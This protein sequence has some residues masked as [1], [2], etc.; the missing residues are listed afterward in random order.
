MT[1][2]VIIFSAYVVSTFVFYFIANIVCK[3][4]DWDREMLLPASLAW[5]CTLIGIVFFMIF[6]ALECASDSVYRKIKDLIR[7]RKKKKRERKENK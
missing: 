3:L 6:Y 7:K 4:I 2:F 5:P 1:K